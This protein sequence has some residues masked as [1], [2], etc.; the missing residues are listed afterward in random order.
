M[1][2]PWNRITQPVYSLVTHSPDKHWN[3]NICT[4]VTPVSMDPKHYVL[5]LD[6][7][8]HTY[9]NFASSGQGILQMLSKKNL[10]HVEVLGKKTG[11]KIDK[12]EHFKS[13]LT[14]V[15]TNIFILQDLIGYLVIE[16]IKKLDPHGG[17][18]ALFL[19]QVSHFKNFNPELQPLN[20]QDLIEA[21][22]ILQPRHR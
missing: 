21:G 12:F 2:R 22:L 18:H 13:K 5:A 7:K 9:E 8:S 4:Y 14:E 10:D 3:A 17:D 19:V 15:E 20:L 11:K 6:P 1:R 16:N